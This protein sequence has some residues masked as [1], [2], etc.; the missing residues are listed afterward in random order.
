MLAV[1]MKVA[2]MVVVMAVVTV[3]L[4]ASRPATSAA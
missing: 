4:R 2:V 3:Y 1:R